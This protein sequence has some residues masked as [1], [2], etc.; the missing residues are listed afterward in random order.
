MS[1]LKEVQG[2]LCSQNILCAFLGEAF[3]L[4]NR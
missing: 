3:H 1:S 2:L 4:M